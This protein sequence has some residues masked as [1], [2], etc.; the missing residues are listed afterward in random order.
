MTAFWILL[1]VAGVA[2][3]ADWSAVARADR[4]LEYVA[5]P[6]VLVALTVTASTIPLS[7]TDL[8]DRRWW[9]VAAL[10][11]C[12]VGDVLLMLRRGLFVAGL[13]AFLVGHILFAVG[14]L[15]GPVPP[16]VPPFTFSAVGLAVA[17]AVVVVVEALPF[18]VLVGALRRDGRGPLVPPVAVYTAAIGTVVVLA[19]N[20]GIALAA[21]GA[22]SFLVSDTLL[23][24]DR[25]VRP[26]RQGPVAVHVT[27]HLAQTL[28]VLSL[29]R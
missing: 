25:F 13:A 16:G 3:V 17:A 11:W 12:L 14:L 18:A 26:L 10:A 9:F 28:L 4:H 20:V 6:T 5:K 27:Y 24:F 22:V 7:H 21:L 2:A 15:Q 23:S 8:A 1:A 29:L 19:T